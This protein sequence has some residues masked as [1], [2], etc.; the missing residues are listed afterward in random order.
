MAILLHNPL[1]NWG[2]NLTKH[3]NKILCVYHCIIHLCSFSLIAFLQGNIKLGWQQKIY[4]YSQLPSHFNVLILNTWL[5][6]S[7]EKWRA[8]S[9]L[10]SFHVPFHMSAPY[11][12]QAYPALLALYYACQQFFIFNHDP[13]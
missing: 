7:S 6:G 5:P 13:Y 1:H 8:A 2:G 10:A 4:V 9:R 12:T 11:S 3:S